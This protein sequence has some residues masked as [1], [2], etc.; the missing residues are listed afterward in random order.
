MTLALYLLRVAGRTEYILC[1]CE[2]V[3][4]LLPDKKLYEFIKLVKDGYCYKLVV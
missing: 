1:V 4:A 3:K 2:L